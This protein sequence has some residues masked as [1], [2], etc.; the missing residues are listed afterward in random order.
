MVQSLL[1]SETQVSSI[2]GSEDLP[3]TRVSGGVMAQA[4]AAPRASRAVTIPEAT[5]RPALA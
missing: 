2:W 4:Q 3:S 5:R 1:S